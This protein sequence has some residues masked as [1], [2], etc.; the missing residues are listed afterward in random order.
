MEVA[1][2]I[3]VKNEARLLRQ[4]IFY[5]LG[6]GVKKMFIYFDNTTDGGRELV[7]SIDGVFCSESITSNKYDD[8]PYLKKFTNQK[9]TQHSARQCINSYD[10]ELQCIKEGIDWLI[11]ID[12]DEFFLLPRSEG[13]KTIQEFFNSASAQNY[14]IVRFGVFEVIPRKMKYDLVAIEETLF[15]TK[16]NFKS[17]FD[18]IYFEI[19]DP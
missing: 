15:K 13:Y 1:I 18:Q 6:I 14:D 11:S 9:F 3:T 17:K 19:T 16:K 8:L 2:V 7:E 10:A 4:N 5:H 12:A